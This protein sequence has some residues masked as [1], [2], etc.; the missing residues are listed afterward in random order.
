MYSEL[1]YFV[2]IRPNYDFYS[3]GNADKNKSVVITKAEYVYAKY[4][5]KN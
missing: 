2:V 4:E 3:N 1:K 5:L